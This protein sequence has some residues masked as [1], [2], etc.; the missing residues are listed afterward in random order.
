MVEATC[1]IESQGGFVMQPVHIAAKQ[2]LWA[3]SAALWAPFP[4]QPAAGF[5]TLKTSSKGVWLYGEGAAVLAVEWRGGGARPCSPAPLLTCTLRGSQQ[6]L[7]APLVPGRFSFRALCA[8]HGSASTTHVVIVSVEG[9]T[10]LPATLAF[11]FDATHAGW[12]C[13]ATLHALACAQVQA[14]VQPAGAVQQQLLQQ[15]TRQQQQ[16]QQTHRL[17]TSVEGQELDLGSPPTDEQLLTAIQV[18]GQSHARQARP[19]SRGNSRRT[20]TDWVGLLAR[21]ASSCVRAEPPLPQGWPSA[22]HACPPTHPPACR[23]IW[24]TQNLGPLWT[25]WR[26][27][28]WRWSSRVWLGRPVGV[29]W[30]QL[31]VEGELCS[32]CALPEQ[33]DQA[34]RQA[35]RSACHPRGHSEQI[36]DPG[37]RCHRHSS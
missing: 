32:G 4:E 7:S 22:A 14:V 17:Q 34:G 3:G 37:A 1:R 16:E 27:C 9:G 8:E 29:E 19:Q 21:W 5:A 26:S 15:Q 2:Q 11:K 31:W 30:G 36:G 28:G 33:R 6:V 13:A 18:R 35:G 20:R 25:G 24:R 12:E 23:L 10:Q